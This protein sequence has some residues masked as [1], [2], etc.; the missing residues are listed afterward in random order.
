M[1]ICI[2]GDRIVNKKEAEHILK[3]KNF[4]IEI[5]LVERKTRVIP[6][7]IGENGTVPKSFR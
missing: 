7:I 1:D 4:T 5:E 2:S 6:V 3:Y